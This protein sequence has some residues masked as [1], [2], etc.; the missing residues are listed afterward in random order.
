M[1]SKE[2]LDKGYRIHNYQAKRYWGRGLVITEVVGEVATTNHGIAT[3]KN[4]TTNTTAP[5]T[6]IKALTTNS[7]AFTTNN[8]HTITEGEPITNMGVA[9]IPGLQVLRE[10]AL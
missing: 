7:K 8:H 4:P 6:N 3:T 2:Q 5:T 9:K 1:R 10:Q